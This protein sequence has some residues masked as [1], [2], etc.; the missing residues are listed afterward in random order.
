MGCDLGFSGVGWPISCGSWVGGFNLVLSELSI[1][2]C[3]N[4][5]FFKID[6]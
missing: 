3:W 1:A 6:L 2:L 5:F 4:F